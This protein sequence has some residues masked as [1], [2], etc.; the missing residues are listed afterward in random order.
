MELPQ[1]KKDLMSK[2]IHNG[3]LAPQ[4][5]SDRFEIES[6]TPDNLP[7]E[8]TDIEKIIDHRKT[9]DTIENKHIIDSMLKC[10]Y[11]NISNGLSGVSY[12][13]K[14]NR[15]HFQYDKDMGIII[16]IRVID[17]YS[18]NNPPK[19]FIIRSVYHNKRNYISQFE[20]SELYLCRDCE[21]YCWSKNRI[22]IPDFILSE[23]IK[24]IV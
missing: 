11:F 24:R 18:N 10:N 5:K 8:L 2:Q 23:F 13:F 1:Y 15:H 4:V 16:A 17:K 21:V 3:L 22:I 7:T 9:S 20:L 19:Y 12:R 6:F 14:T